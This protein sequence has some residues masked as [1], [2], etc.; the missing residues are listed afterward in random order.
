M[1]STA[2]A[3]ENSATDDDIVTLGKLLPIVNNKEWIERLTKYDEIT[4]IQLRIKGESD[5]E[6]INTIVQECQE[7]CENNNVRLWINDFWKA[8]VKAKC[9]GV[10][11]GQEDL[12]KCIDEGG[13][14]IIRDNNMALGISTHS[15]AEL[16]AAFGVRPSY[17]SLG[18]VFGTKS[19]DVAFDPQGLDTVKKWKELIN[20]SV[21]LVAIG[22][23][24]DA[25]IVSTVKEAGADCV[26]VISAITKADDVGNAVRQ[27]DNAMN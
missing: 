24:N 23:I 11:V 8:A 5:E 22:G 13:L 10:H 16:S 27:L 17:I 9:F 7:I 1:Q 15:F 20:P 18:P 4:D 3:M 21:P 14:D 19:K 6:K 25:S 12:G 2:T 26:A